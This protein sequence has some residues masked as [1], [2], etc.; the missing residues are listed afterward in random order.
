MVRDAVLQRLLE[1]IKLR[2]LTE[3]EMERKIGLSNGTFTKWKYHGVKTYLQ[4][5]GPMSE[6]LDVSPQYL[7]YGVDDE[8]N[9]DVMTPT[10]VNLVQMY[11]KLNSR[12][13]DCL[14]R[15]AKAFLDAD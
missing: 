7:L 14:I 5:I 6:C 3:K 4:H 1:M 10:E 13:K 12:Q 15:T 11:R 8:V 2:G 9:M